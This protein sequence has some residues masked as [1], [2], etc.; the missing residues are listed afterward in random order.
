MAHVQKWVN[1]KV[2]DNYSQ[3]APIVEVDAV[4]YWTPTADKSV[5]FT[6]VKDYILGLR[7]AGFKIRVCTFDR[8]NS[9]DMMQQLK[10]YGINTETLSVAKKHY[11]DMAMVVLEERLSG[12][13]IPLLIDELLQLKIMRDKVDHPRKGSKDLA[14]AVCGSIY[15]AISRTKPENSSEIEIHTYDPMRWDRED[16]EVVRDNL[17]RAPR[18]PD[19]LK[20]VLDGMEIV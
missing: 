1:I 12:P 16:T 20:D 7:S 19:Y 18:M 11:D 9:H 13:H 14:D 10:Q 4:R 5:D 2:T 6:E 8:W 15:N 3:A 17:I